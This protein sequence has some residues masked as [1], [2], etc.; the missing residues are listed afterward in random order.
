MTMTSHVVVIGGGFAGVAAAARLR[1]NGARVTLLDARDALGGRARSDTLDGVAI[2]TGAQI[3]SSAFSHTRRL[4]EHGGADALRATPGRDMYVQDGRRLPIQFGSIRSLLTFGGLGAVT[5]LKLAS[6]LLPLLARHR[7]HLD[8]SAARLPESLDGES[9]RHY[10]ERH[11]G[12]D[13]ADVLV[14]PPLNSFY[15]TRGSE[16][17]LGFFLTLGHYGSDSDVLAPAA[18]WTRALE[19]SLTGVT[20][21]LAARVDAVTPKAT[22][23]GVIVRAGPREWR[24]H[25][26]VVAT[27]PLGARELVR[28][29]PGVPPDLIA[30]LGEL[31]L[32]KTLTLALAVDARVTREVFGIFGHPSPARVVSACAV[33][34][35]KLGEHAPPSGDV[36]L[37]WPSPEVA[38]RLADAPADEVVRTMLPEVEALVPEV[39]GRVRRA[40]VYRVDEGTPLARP[41]FGAHRQRGRALAASI[42][43]PV[44]LA[45]DYLTMPLIEG[46]VISGEM[47]ADQLL[48]RLG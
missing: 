21:E 28:H 12:S 30:W 44:T 37:A 31:E 35:A 23:G 27:G 22:G 18:G 45:G 41:G 42:E 40:R 32:R 39:R 2:D 17:S 3:V 29:L 7:S 47:A 5:K 1:A 25:G 15:A 19:R 9:A 34:G 6:S 11:V 46:A 36:V 33:H 43:A 14:E 4:L 24:A 48:A 16:A 20:H 38:W 26:A 8:A 10:V 13:A